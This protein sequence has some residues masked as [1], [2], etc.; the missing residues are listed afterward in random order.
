MKKSSLLALLAVIILAL[1]FAGCGG[2]GGG[3]GSM[4]GDTENPPD[5]G[6]NSGTL[7]V[8]TGK[9]VDQDTG[10][11][12]QNVTV[13]VTNKPGLMTTYKTKTTSTGDFQ[14]V[15]QQDVSILSLF[16]QAL[17]PSFAIVA[18]T[19]GTKY[20]DS[21]PVLYNSISYSQGNIKFAM[22]NL[23]TNGRLGQI[24]I[25]STTQNSGGGGIE[26]PPDAPNP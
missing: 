8:I 17:D 4:G 20:L 26:D 11:G 19:A 25:K 10:D 7:T 5:P 24:G 9:V 22:A 16:D 3:G 15:L 23:L 2:G 6:E 13:Y 18:S 14:V 21:T 12:V 1:A